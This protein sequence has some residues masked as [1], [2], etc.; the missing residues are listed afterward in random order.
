MKDKKITKSS[1]WWITFYTTGGIALLLLIVSF[2]LPPTGQIDPSV[3]RATAEILGFPSLLAAYEL[4]L[5]AITF[6]YTK[7]DTT[8][9]I[10]NPDN[11]DV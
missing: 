4:G 7:G 1:S 9:E 5:R 6:R 10:I 3:L 11:K 2:I 8:I